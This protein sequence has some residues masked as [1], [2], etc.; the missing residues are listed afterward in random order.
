MKKVEK[1][2]INMGINGQWLKLESWLVLFV[3]RLHLVLRFAARPGGKTLQVRLGILKIWGPF[4][5]D[6]LFSFYIFYCI[7]LCNM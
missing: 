4:P 1:I 6:V 5:V 2:W 7:I 3:C